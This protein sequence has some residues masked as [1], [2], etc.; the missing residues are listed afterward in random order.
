MKI[1]KVILGISYDWLFLIMSEQTK[2]YSNSA[3]KKADAIDF[4]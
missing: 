2:T 4:I 1:N 3:T